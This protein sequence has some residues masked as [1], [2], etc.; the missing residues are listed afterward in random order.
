MAE[1]SF[2]T[3]S[4]VIAAA[5]LCKAALALAIPRRFYAVRERQYASESL[6]PK[7]LLAPVVVVALT[8]TAWYATIL[9]YQPWG[10][11]VTGLLTA[12]SC[13]A[14]DHLF[15]WQSHLCWVSL[16]GI[17]WPWPEREVRLT[18]RSTRAADL[19]DSESTFYLELQRHRPLD[20]LRWKASYSCRIGLASNLASAASLGRRLPIHHV[21]ITVASE[22]KRPQV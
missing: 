20:H 2:R 18:R 6:P 4:F 15:R 3:L 11:I 16:D 14:V 10:W 1:V 22:R 7:L 8:L 21:D 13:L 19:A 17:L 12:L 5:L 9:H